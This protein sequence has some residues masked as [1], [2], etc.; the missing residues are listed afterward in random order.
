MLTI[1]IDFADAQAE[2]T[3][4]VSKKETGRSY[5][6]DGL[7]TWTTRTTVEYSW[8]ETAEQNIIPV[9]RIKPN[10]GSQNVWEAA[11]N[12]GSTAVSGQAANYYTF[13]MTYS[14]ADPG[15][16]ASPLPYADKIEA[17]KGELPE[18]LQN[19]QNNKIEYTQTF[20]VHTT[21]EKYGAAVMDVTNR[22]FDDII[23]YYNLVKPKPKA[24]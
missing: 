12:L 14:G 6:Y 16:L 17:F 11:T 1:Y 8:G 2:A 7:G 13:N 4:F 10:L 20:E 21:P 19:R 5:S 24:R 18:V 15:Y 22:F 3:A 23:T 9:V